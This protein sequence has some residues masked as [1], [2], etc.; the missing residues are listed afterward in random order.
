MRSAPELSERL[1]GSNSDAPVWVD[2]AGTLD[3]RA[4]H[5]EIGRCL[6]L[7][8]A[9]G[10]RPGD[11]V[12]VQLAPGASLFALLLAIWRHDAAV[13]LLDHRLTEAETEKLAR[14]C[15][16]AFRVRAPMPATRFTARSELVVEAMTGSVPLPQDVRLVQFTSG[17]TGQ[18]K[19]VGRSA[20]SL[21]VEIDRYAAVDDMPGADD[22]LL[23][24][25]S[26]VHTWGLVGGVLYG[27]A[28]GMP[29]LFPSAQHGAAVVRAATA[30]EPTAVFGVTTHFDMLGRTAGL[31]R[32]PHL[33]V[34][35][36]AGMITGPAVAERFQQASGCPLGQVYGLT[37][38]GVVTADL[39]GRF[40]APSVGR[41]APGIT[42][43]SSD[44]E[45]HVWLPRSPYLVEDGVDRFSDGWLRT[46]D[47]ARVDEV[48]GAVTILGRADSVVAVGGIKID[49]MEVEQVLQE[50]P[51]VLNA[52]VTFGNV[53]EAHVAARPGLTDR[54]LAAW[55]R[56]RLNPLKSPKRYY[57]HDRLIQ[58]PTG[59]VVRDREQLLSAVAEHRPAADDAGD[60]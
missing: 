19:V 33:R 30:L 59:K 41:P 26:P 11:C 29:V 43:R 14:L 37:E 23:L 20:A 40:A 53:I 44:D 5:E 56:E 55:S 9:T 34:A 22:R 57:L 45:L 1:S 27:L 50:H 48:S 10:V 4:L 8:V 3:R 16:P 49:L 17:S 36:S 54:A 47:R 35:T 31:P 21:D 13:M 28:T 42:V 58:T 7:L 25:C 32:M 60:Q 52:V 12:A 24:L 46:F 51:D 2:E 38:T 39:T 18:S 6:D 15:L